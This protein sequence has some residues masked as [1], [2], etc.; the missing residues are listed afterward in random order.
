MF[1]NIH[2]MKIDQT[3]DVS[4]NLYN[5]S[6]SIPVHFWAPEVFSVF[7]LLFLSDHHHTASETNYFSSFLQQ[8]ISILSY[9][10]IIV[11]L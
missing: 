4:C 10:F 8:F 2:Y 1:S 6:V 5:Y 7:F 3:N 11:D 9:F